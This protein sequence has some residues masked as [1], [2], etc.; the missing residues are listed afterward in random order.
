MSDSI[1]QGLEGVVVSATKISNVDGQRGELVYAGY[2]LE[3]VIEHAC[4]YEAVLFLF[5]NGKLPTPEESKDFAANLAT[6]RTLSDETLAVVDALPTGLNYMD[7]LRSAMSALGC[8]VIPVTHP[9]KNKL[10]RLSPKH[11]FF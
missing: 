9:H 8:E 11:R 5:L 4:C 7:A 2:M 3:E 10:L 1:N 6:H